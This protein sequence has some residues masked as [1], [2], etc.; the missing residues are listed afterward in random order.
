LVHTRDV[1]N[2]TIFVRKQTR[3]KQDGG[4][5]LNTCCKETWWNV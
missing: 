2:K 1:P 3:D 4:M 5:I